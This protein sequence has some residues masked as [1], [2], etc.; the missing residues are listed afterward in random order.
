MIILN[1]KIGRKI[2]PGFIFIIP[3]LFAS[4]IVFAKYPEPQWKWGKGQPVIIFSKNVKRIENLGLKLEW[5]GEQSG[6]VLLKRDEFSLL[7]ELGLSYQII[8]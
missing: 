5:M 2:L 7:G 6:L 8:T 3:L 1:L 4:G